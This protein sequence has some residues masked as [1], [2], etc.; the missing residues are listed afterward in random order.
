MRRWFAKITIGLYLS[1]LSVGIISHAMNFGTFSH[2]AMYYIV[3]DMFC[4]W[5][6]HEIR[7]HVIAEGESG[8]Y[9]DVSQGPWGTFMPYGDLPRSQY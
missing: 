7:Y 9:Y 6:A 2:P 3:W 5:T 8:T 1:V 4:G